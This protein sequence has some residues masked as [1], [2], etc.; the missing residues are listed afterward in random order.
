MLTLVCLESEHA[1]PPDLPVG[2]SKSREQAPHVQSTTAASMARD[3]R[4][5]LNDPFH[6]QTFRTAVS[7]ADSRPSLANCG[8]FI[9]SC[10]ARLA[11]CKSLRFWRGWAHLWSR[12][13]HR[14]DVSPLLHRTP[15]VR[16]LFLRTVTRLSQSMPNRG[17]LTYCWVSTAHI[18]CTHARRGVR[19]LGDPHALALRPG[20]QRWPD[21]LCE[22]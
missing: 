9:T 3:I 17:C 12:R 18:C 19:W 13:R 6:P 10:G 15:P 14:Q 5:P 1:A 16:S 8:Q 11:H 4:V 2:T 21:A 22:G 7:T 20:R